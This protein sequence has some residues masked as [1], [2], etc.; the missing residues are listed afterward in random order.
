MTR[1]ETRQWQLSTHLSLVKFDSIIQSLKHIYFFELNV[2]LLMDCKNPSLVFIDSKFT[3]GIVNIWLWSQSSNKA[4]ALIWTKRKTYAPSIFRQKTNVLNERIQYFNFLFKHFRNQS[5]VQPIHHFNL[6]L[7]VFNRR[8]RVAFA[9][10]VIT[11]V[12]YYRLKALP[13]DHLSNISS[14]TFSPHKRLKISPTFSK[15]ETRQPCSS[16]IFEIDPEC[17]S[18]LILNWFKGQR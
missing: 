8:F 5:N 13:W 18:K 1:F 17:I 9:E 11:N 6:E 4:L 16:A 2:M 3:K 14:L 15:D 10:Y 12:N 7:F